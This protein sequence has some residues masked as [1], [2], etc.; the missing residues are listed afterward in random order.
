MVNG[1]FPSPEDV[2][3]LQ[4]QARRTQDPAAQLRGAAFNLG[5]QGGAA[6]SRGFGHEVPNPI[7]ERAANV[8][9]IAKQIDFRNP[10]SIMDAANA[11]N[12]K[13]YQAEAF[14]LLGMLPK[15]ATSFGPMQSHD[16][17]ITDDSGNKTLKRVYGQTNSEGEFFK[18]YDITSSGQIDDGSGRVSNVRIPE[19]HRTPIRPSE[20]TETFMMEKFR[21]IINAQQ[22]AD[23]D[24]DEVRKKGI[25]GKLIKLASQARDN[26]LV[27]LLDTKAQIEQATG[28]PMKQLELDVLARKMVP[29]PE[30]LMDQVFQTY[31]ESNDFRND[32]SRSMIPGVDPE[33]GVAA[34][35]VTNFDSLERAQ[36]AGNEK[37]ATI[38]KFAAEN[39]DLVKGDPR[40]KAWALGNINTSQ[41]KEMFGDLRGIPKNEDLKTSF[42]AQGF[43]FTP[44]LYASHAKRWD[45]MRDYPD[46][47]STY[48]VY[49]D[50]PNLQGAKIAEF[51]SN[52]QDE[53]N[54]YKALASAE[55]FK[56]LKRL[57]GDK[58]KMT[59]KERGRLLAQERAAKQKAKLD[60]LLG[61]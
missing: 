58:S 26:Q 32:F 34:T 5:H 49:A 27:K 29:P 43:Q 31:I 30:Q 10:N 17:E 15:P 8:Q 48:F 4:E 22:F 11:M 54:T 53:G 42:E 13:G 59:A 21:G 2:A 6:I 51:I 40:T 60:K 23:L 37:A 33:V 45:Y 35:G 47:V 61:N 24:A 36:K 50:S 38:S 1:L 44:E 41:A 57:K 55:V 9:G 3:I 18:K 14:K 19:M 16:I 56:Y 20:Q 12:D 7:K 25:E 52:A 46:S 39:A 28:V